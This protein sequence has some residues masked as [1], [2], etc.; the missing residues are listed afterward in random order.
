MDRRGFIFLAAFIAGLEYTLQPRQQADWLDPPSIRTAVGVL[1]AG[2][3]FCLAWGDDAST[4]I[5]QPA[6][7]RIGTSPPRRPS[8]PPW[9]CRC[10]VD[11]PARLS[12]KESCSSDLRDGPGDG[13]A[14]VGQ[15]REHAA[16]GS[17][18]S[19]ARSRDSSTSASPRASSARWMLT[20]ISPDSTAHYALSV[21]AAGLRHR[22]R[23]IPLSAVAFATPPPGSPPKLPASTT[24]SDRSA[25]R[26]AI[27]RQCVYDP[28]R[29]GELER[30][31]RLRRSLSR[32]GA[33]VSGPDAAEGAGRG[34]CAHRRAGGTAGAELGLLQAFWLIVASSVANDPRVMLLKPAE[35][36]PPRRSR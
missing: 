4:S 27:D 16:G 18:A 1:I 35:R 3:V 22:F 14:R 7:S 25:R 36:V 10:T 21:P 29:A 23:V 12:S 13:A 9:G 15:P 24:S 30:A 19:Q 20:R 11:A 17:P 31:A 6:P 26:S 32:P 28:R 33:A 2:R 34:P 5:I 8:Q